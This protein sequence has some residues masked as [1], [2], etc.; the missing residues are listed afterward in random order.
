MRN[1]LDAQAKLFI[2][3]QIRMMRKRYGWSQAQL[4]KKSGQTQGV[5]S[6]AENPRKG[7]TV[8]TLL[9]IAA[10]LDTE[11][12]V[13]FVPPGHLNAPGESPGWSQ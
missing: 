13:Q 7:I 10:A 1:F 8:S 11:L 9:K 5:I 12:S 6:R 2:P 4:A 3:L